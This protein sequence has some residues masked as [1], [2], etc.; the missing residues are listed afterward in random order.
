MSRRVLRDGGTIREQKES[1]RSVIAGGVI[2]AKSAPSVS[3]AKIDQAKPFSEVPAAFRGFGHYSSGLFNLGSTYLRRE[4]IRFPDRGESTMTLRKHGS[5]PARN[6]SLLQVLNRS[7]DSLPGR[8]HQADCHQRYG[9]GRGQNKSDGIGNPEHRVTSTSVSR[10][11]SRQPGDPRQPTGRQR[12][13]S[14]A[15][16]SR[17]RKV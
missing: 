5:P 14:K 10:A 6:I 17:L 16:C 4:S 1:R 9:N 12:R 2:A 11:R 13:R 7:K 8:K 3:S 15:D